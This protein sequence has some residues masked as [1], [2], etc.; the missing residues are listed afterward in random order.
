LP[1]IKLL[2]RIFRDKNISFR[3]KVEACNAQP[4]RELMAG[5]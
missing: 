4:G 5:D 1:A 2:P 3:E